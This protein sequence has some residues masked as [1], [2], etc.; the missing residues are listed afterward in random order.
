MVEKNAKNPVQ[1]A[2]SPTDKRRVPVAG[3]KGSTMGDVAEA[4]RGW[5]ESMLVWV[6]YGTLIG[7]VAKAIMPGRDPGGTV[8]TLVMGV[9]GVIVGCG[10][11]SFFADGARISPLSPVGAIVG[12]VGALALLAFYRLLAGYFIT[13]G[14][15]DLK[16][17]AMQRR[18]RRYKRAA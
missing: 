4:I 3:G 1:G 17:H 8:A 6:G 11:V 14:E 9:G 10:T 2:K 12:A 5:T 16:V 13:E 18:R 7:I 15:T